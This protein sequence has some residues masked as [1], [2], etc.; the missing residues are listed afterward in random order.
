MLKNR[1]FGFWA[2]KPLKTTVSFK[3]KDGKTVTFK[4]IKVIKV[5]KKR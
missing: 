5:K 3:T 2:T 1:K 4:A